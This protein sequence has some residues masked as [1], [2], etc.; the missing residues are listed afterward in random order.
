VGTL[1]NVVSVLLADDDDIF[2]EHLTRSAAGEDGLR[3]LGSASDGLEVARL[4]GLLQPTVVVAGQMFATDRA[5][6]LVAAIRR[7]SPETAVVIACGT[8]VRS[9]M[10]RALAEGAQGYFVKDLPWPEIAL[11]LRA[12]AAGTLALGPRARAMLEGAPAPPP[13]NHGHA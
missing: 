8:L 3:V 10:T 2:C 11:L 12:A 4:A 1:S 9:S 6:G 5:P 13:V 7:A